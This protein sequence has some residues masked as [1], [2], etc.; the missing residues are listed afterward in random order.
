[1][2]IVS[3]FI[4]FAFVSFSPSQKIEPNKIILIIDQIDAMR[5]IANDIETFWDDKEYFDTIQITGKVSVKEINETLN[6]L[7]IAKSQSEISYQTCIIR[8]LDE[9]A[10]DTFYGWAWFDKWQKGNTMYVDKTKQLNKLFRNFYIHEW[11][12]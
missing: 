2:K 4:L 3:L 10:V 12:K 1:M 11:I 5:P 7:S 8:Y 9:K 6:K